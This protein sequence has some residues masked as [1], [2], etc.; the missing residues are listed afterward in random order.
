MFKAIAIVSFAEDLGRLQCVSAWYYC[1][2]MVL[3]LLMFLSLPSGGTGPL[4]LT[5]GHD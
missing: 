5:L 1:C 4:A 2:C 3:L